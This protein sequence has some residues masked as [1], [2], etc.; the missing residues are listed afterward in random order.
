MSYSFNIKAAT[1]EAAKLAVL[2]K[3]EEITAQQPM[4]ARDRRAVLVNAGAVIDL[5]ADDDTKDISVSCNGY[6]SWNGSGEFTA[7]TAPV[8]TVSISCTANHATRA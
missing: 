8:G 5:L 2:D 4:H 1:K 3:F 7:E 6:L